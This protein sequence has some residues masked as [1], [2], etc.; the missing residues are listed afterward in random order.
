MFVLSTKARKSILLVTQD[1]IMNPE[2]DHD[3]FP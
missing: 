2:N 1:K 3:M